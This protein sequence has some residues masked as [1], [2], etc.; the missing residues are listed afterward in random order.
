MTSKSDHHL[1]SSADVNGTNVY[2]PSGEIVGSIDHLMI[3]KV[4]GKVTYAVMGFGGFLGMG[5]EHYPI[6]WGKL[7]YDP[8]KEGFVT[9]ITS[10]QLKSAPDRPG[11]WAANRDWQTRDHDHYGVPYPWY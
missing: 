8:A 6:P 7:T 2:A 9:D 4:S 1:V 10:E 3:E 11:D 5:E